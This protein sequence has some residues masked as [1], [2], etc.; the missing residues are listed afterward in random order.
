VT[1]QESESSSVAHAIFSPKKPA[2][3]AGFFCCP[4]LDFQPLARSNP[5]FSK[6]ACLKASSGELR[7][8]AAELSR[9]SL[10]QR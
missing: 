2:L 10:W 1:N 7:K 9:R 5:D 6:L 8:L 4:K 3:V